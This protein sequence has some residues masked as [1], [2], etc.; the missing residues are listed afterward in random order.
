MHGNA[1]LLKECLL[2]WCLCVTMTYDVSMFV[3]GLLYPHPLAPCPPRRP[4][5][6]PPSGVRR[7]R[8]RPAVTLMTSILR[9]PKRWSRSPN[10]PGKSKFTY[11]SDGLAQ[12]TFDWPSQ[13][14]GLC[15]FLRIS[16]LSTSPSVKCGC[17]PLT[18]W[19]L[20]LPYEVSFWFTLVPWKSIAGKLI[21]WTIGTQS[22][23]KKATASLSEGR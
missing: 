6:V 18:T 20:D 16:A 11:L 23:C 19:F 9:L 21:I 5:P 15:L 1:F 22:R 7:R 8:P 12:I 13:E 17:R 3:T 10:R 4:R 14:T 2:V